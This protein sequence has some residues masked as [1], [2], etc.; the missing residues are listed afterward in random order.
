MH[1]YYSN[2]KQRGKINDT[3]NFVEWNI[4]LSSARV[5]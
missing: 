5:Q 3:F 1:S 2:R 4:I